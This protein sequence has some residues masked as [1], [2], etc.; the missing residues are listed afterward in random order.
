[1]DK[2]TSANSCCDKTWLVKATENVVIPP[3][4]HQIISGKLDLEKG[5]TP[6]QTVCIEPAPIPTYG[7]LPARVLS[8]VGAE[9]D[10]ALQLAP[11]DKK[12]QGQG[13]R[14]LLM[15]TNFSNEPLEIPKSTVVGIAESSSEILVNKVNTQD[16]SREKV[17]YEARFSET[18]ETG[19]TGRIRSSQSRPAR[20]QNIERP[21]EFAET[22]TSRSRGSHI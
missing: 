20:R 1:V 19:K 16:D 15:L 7:I 5:H 14:A 4:S 8:R 21:R 17:V 6:P 9:K 11:T 18:F 13:D 2:P 3:R 10:Q 22:R 12:V